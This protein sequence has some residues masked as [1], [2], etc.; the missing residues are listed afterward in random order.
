LIG[1]NHLLPSMQAGVLI[2]E[3]AFD[4]EARHPTAGR[5]R[6]NRCDTVKGEPQTATGLRPGY[7]QSAA[8]DREFLCQ[9]QAIPRHRHSL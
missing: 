8:P 3:K 7:L 5:R 1:A 2:A 4:A 9:A 6:K